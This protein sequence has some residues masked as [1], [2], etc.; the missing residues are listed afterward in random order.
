VQRKMD[1]TAGMRGLISRGT[2]AGTS[3]EIDMATSST[4]QVIRHLRRIILQDGSGLTDGQLLACFIEGRDEPAFAALVQRHGR[5]VWNVCR[6]LLNAHDAEDA[7]QATFLVLCRKAASIRCREMLASWLYRV[8]H[9]TAMRARRA[10]VRRRA[11]EKQVVDMPEP[12]VAERDLWNDLQPLLDQE[13]ARLPDHYQ[14]LILLCD[15]EGKTRKEVARQLDLPEGT[16]A[17][18]LARA[19]SLLAK[20]LARHGLAVTGGTLAVVLSDEALAASVPTS[21]ASGT[22]QAASLVAAGQAAAIPV[23]VAALT[24]GV[25][26]AMLVSKLKIGTAVLFMMAALAAGVTIRTLDGQTQASDPATAQRATAATGEKTAGVPKPTSDQ[27]AMQGRWKVVA[28]EANGWSEQNGYIQSVKITGDKMLLRCKDGVVDETLFRLDDSQKPKHIDWVG[29][30]KKGTVSSVGIYHVDGD[31]LVLCILNGEK[32]RGRPPRFE[33]EPGDGLWL[34]V[35]EREKPIFPLVPPE[36]EG[37][38]PAELK[39]R[40]PR[41]VIEVTI[42]QETLQGTWDLIALE[43]NGKQA[44][45]FV[46]RTLTINADRI[47][48]DNPIAPRTE[49]RYVVRPTTSPKQ[50]D[51]IHTFG[52]KEGKILKGIYRL[53]GNRLFLCLNQAEDGERPARFAA[54]AGTTVELMLFER[55]KGEEDPA[56]AGGAPGARKQRTEFKIGAVSYTLPFALPSAEEILQAL[57]AK[58]RPKDSRIECELLSY[59]TNPPRFYPGVGPARLVNAHFR[60]TVFNLQTG[61]AVI[62]YIDRDHLIPEK[63]DPSEKSQGR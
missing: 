5:L 49:F 46:R 54:E 11:R 19:R 3:S 18:R 14:V 36:A 6:R 26:K 13:L 4:S 51:L 52:V 38:D 39:L 59:Q 34:M 50:I 41:Q 47:V 24:E 58:D 17:S 40:I 23:K 25:V 2:S 37:R 32:K 10:V 33:T 8:A 31:R 29:N 42:R 21:V 28:W 43:A 1:Q 15:L 60:Y 63:A 27:E 48:V 44:H 22:I 20:R 56:A 53:E 7:F 12:T 45:A 16:V 61:K 55:E 57:P 35:L 9:Q 62:G 30:K